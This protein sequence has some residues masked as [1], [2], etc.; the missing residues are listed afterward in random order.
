MYSFL[1]FSQEVP[2]I[3]VGVGFPSFFQTN[4][5]EDW[6]SYHSIDPGRIHA[7]TEIQQLIKFKNNPAFSVT[8]GIGYFL[9][10]ESESGGGLGG[11]TSTDLKHSALSM[12]AKLNY[13]ITKNNEKPFRWYGGV[14]LGFYLYSKTTG[15]RNWWRMEQLGGRWGSSEIDKSGKAFF[16]SFYNG[17]YAGFKIK[18][19]KSDRFQPAFEFSFLPGYANITDRYLSDENKDESLTKSMIMGSVIFGFGTKKATRINE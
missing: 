14:L 9:F 19:G 6:G 17:I 7:F 16:N 4:F 5:D 1:V 15:E 2:S 12:Y 3:N 11:G 10:N 8:P 18:A 13:S